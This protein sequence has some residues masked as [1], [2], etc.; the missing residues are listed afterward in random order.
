MTHPHLTTAHRTGNRPTS[1]LR[2]AELAGLAMAMA[3][4]AFSP[5]ASAAGAIWDRPRT[6]VVDRVFYGDLDLK[7]ASG[8]RTMLLRMRAAVA[9]ACALPTSPA[10]PTANAEA[11]RCE[12]LG[13][14]RAVRALDAP[15]VNTAY[16]RL[17]PTPP[18]MTAEQR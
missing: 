18:T 9:R 5:T 17:Y 11:S 10:L 6:P 8:A 16:A 1:H 15:L 12:R 4:A 3:L 13:L 7:T 2:T 14:A